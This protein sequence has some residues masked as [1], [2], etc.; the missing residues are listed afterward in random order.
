MPGFLWSI[1]L[2]LWCASEPPAQL[3]NHLSVCI[4]NKLI[5]SWVLMTAGNPELCVLILNLSPVISGKMPQN[6]G[7]EDARAEEWEPG[8]SE[9]LLWDHR[10]WLCD[11]P[12][13]DLPVLDKHSS[14]FWGNAWNDLFGPVIATQ[15]DSCDPLSS[16]F[17]VGQDGVFGSRLE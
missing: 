8:V 4:L 1:G 6:Q 16:A 15:A 13:P 3:G 11:W 9:Q 12:C 10:L 17:P 2:K 7:Q 14:P 5:S